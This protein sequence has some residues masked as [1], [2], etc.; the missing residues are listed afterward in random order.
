M[1]P[2]RSVLVD[3][4][5]KNTVRELISRG[6]AKTGKSLSISVIYF[7]IVIWADLSYSVCV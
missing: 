5:A 1:F 4:T 2:P 7:G 6:I 3:C